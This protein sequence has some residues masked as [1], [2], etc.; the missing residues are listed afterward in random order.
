MLKGIDVSKW[1][2]HIDFNAV[3]RSG[4]DFVII[5]A[6]YGISALQ[7]DPFFE[8]NYTR[9]KAAGLKVGAYWFSYAKTPD[10]ALKEA[11]ACAAV[12]ANKRFDFPIYYDLETDAKSGY[13][14]FTTGKENCSNM[15]TA[16]CTELEKLGYFAGL[17][18]S[19]SPLQTHITKK[20][21]ERFALWLAE[22]GSKLN[23]SGKY[24]IWQ[25]S[26]TGRVVGVIGNVDIDEAVI[27]YSKI[28]I[29]GGFNGYPKKEQPKEEKP[30]TE[31]P[32]EQPQP[33]PNTEKEKYFDYEIKK[34]DTLTAIAK[35][36]GSTI[37]ELKKINNIKNVHLIYAGDVIKIPVRG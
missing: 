6:G 18:M 19:R 8:V 10:E 32:K 5:Q 29:D 36:F 9:A 15:V 21:A 23:Y 31:K 1:Q 35:A 24:G 14:P 28:I 2:G 12:I 27:D 26:S 3:K 33:A 25:K 13:F 30:Q 34:G 22:Y 17:Y 11:R 4:V 7:K 37:A 20:V 16:F